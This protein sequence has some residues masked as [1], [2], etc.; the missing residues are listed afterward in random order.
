MERHVRDLERERA[1][2]MA[3]FEDRISR[4]RRMRIDTAKVANNLAELLVNQEAERILNYAV[5]RELQMVEALKIFRDAAVTEA[6]AHRSAGEAHN[7]VLEIEERM[8][9][10]QNAGSEAQ[11]AQNE[12]KSRAAVTRKTYDEACSVANGRA[13]SCNATISTQSAELSTLHLHIALAM[14]QFIST[15]TKIVDVKV[16]KDQVGKCF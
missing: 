9:Y 7:A 8:A 1:V 4:L 5:T 3:L 6:E 2:E 12:A 16:T 11:T 10:T 14:H 13:E 15:R